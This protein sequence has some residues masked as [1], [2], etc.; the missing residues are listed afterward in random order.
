MAGYFLPHFAG[1]FAGLSFP[2]SIFSFPV[3]K[4]SQWKKG[5]FLPF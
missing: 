5:L 4:L 3:I 2:T 1:L